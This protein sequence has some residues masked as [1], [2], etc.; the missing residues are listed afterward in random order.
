MNYTHKHNKHTVFVKLLTEDNMRISK[1]F[2]IILI[3]Y[4]NINTKNMKKF[5]QNLTTWQKI[6]AIIILLTLL[7]I[8][9]IPLIFCANIDFNF[10]QNPKN[11]SCL[12]NSDCTPKTCGCL[13][14]QGAKKFSFWTMLCGAR[15]KCIVQP[16]CI[17]QNN[18]CK[19][20][21]GKK[22]KET[23]KTNEVE[24]KILKQSNSIIENI[25]K[26]NAEGSLGPFDYKWET[27]TNCNNLK[28]IKDCEKINWPMKCGCRKDDINS[29]YTCFAELEK[30]A[31]HCK[32]IEED[33][34][35]D[36]C[37]WAVVVQ[38]KKARMEY[39]IDFCDQMSG[40][41]KWDN[42]KGACFEAG[43]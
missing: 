29:C 2:F 22:N 18:N 28:S 30:N 39:K 20:K 8:F 13:N 12:K 23:E 32:N 16:E 35:R 38:L 15:L 40:E 34:Y 5:L 42:Q 1:K 10:T 41:T 21:E 27:E 17:C 43:E 26:L 36:N 19:V 4:F 33:F 3:R 11:I 25:N 31:N 24:K 14:K 6:L 37:Y 9:I 7:F